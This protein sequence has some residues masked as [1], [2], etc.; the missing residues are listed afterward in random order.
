MFLLI[1][2]YSATTQD[3]ERLYKTLVALGTTYPLSRSAYLVCTKQS[4]A[5]VTL[6]VLVA[7][8]SDDHLYVGPLT[9]I[10][11]LPEHARVWIAT[12]NVWKTSTE[13]GASNDLR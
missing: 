8:E 5:E 10:D 1:S 13:N 4:V 6:E 9:Y 2:L 12:Q 3:C 11:Y 7:L